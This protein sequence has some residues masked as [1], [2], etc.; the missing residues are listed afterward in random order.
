MFG[1]KKRKR[2]DL[3]VFYKISW[4]FHLYNDFE[5]YGLHKTAIKKKYRYLLLNVPRI[6]SVNIFK[7][8]MLAARGYEYV[9]NT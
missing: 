3:L 4:Y 5:K 7:G 9:S 6:R 8:L 2:K 1:K